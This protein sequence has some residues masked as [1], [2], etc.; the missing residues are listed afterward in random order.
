[1]LTCRVF[2][3]LGLAAVMVWPG[4]PVAGAEKVLTTTP[5]NTKPSQALKLAFGAQGLVKTVE[6]KEGDV[7]KTGQI[8]ARLDER[9]DQKAYESM[10]LEGDSALKVDYAKAD[11]ALKRV[12]LKRKEDMRADNVASETEVEE[13]RLAVTLAE[14]QVSL[15]SLEQQQK[16]LETERQGIKIEMM[17]LMS[18]VDGRVERIEIGPGESA[19]PSKPSILVHKNDPLWA[20]IYVTTGQARQLR[21]GGTLDV[22]YADEKT[23]APAKVIYIADA[24]PASGTQ[25]VRMELAN[26]GNRA[27]G[28]Q[29]MVS[30]PEP[31]ARAGE[32]QH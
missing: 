13:A 9:M 11:L 1:M 17:H 15:A 21:V 26:P 10:K 18:P 23:Q 30:L 20:E 32:V 24:D 2:A 4:G 29:V 28:M 12:Q 27:S 7:V 3:C 8:L 14:T 6:V 25:L 16:K 22:R 31:I 5:G 19:D